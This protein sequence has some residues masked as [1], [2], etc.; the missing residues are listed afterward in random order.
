M[1]FIRVGLVSI[2]A[3]VLSGSCILAQTFQ[4]RI[5]GRVTDSSG[6]VIPN[7]TVT[8]ENTGTGL[9][10]VLQTNSSGDYFA[11]NLNPG[12]YS[13]N[14][15]APNFKTMRR[16]EIRLEVASDVRIDATLSPGAVSEV[17]QVTGEQPMVDI[18]T[19][20]LGGTMTNKAINELPLQ[21]RDFQ[22]LLELR[23]GV[24]RTP[25]GGFHTVTSNGNRL[26]DNNYTVDGT[27]DNDVYYGETVINDAGVAGTPASHL[28]LDAIQEFNT[29]ENQGAEYGW[30]PGAVVNIG[31]REWDGRRNDESAAPIAEED[32]N[33]QPGETGSDDGLL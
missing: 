16:S 19:D 31:D 23:P 2:L 21:G 25:G 11:P 22:N 8:I 32:Q 28:P 6:A 33:H 4:G 29:Q 1:K 20:T 17:M 10:R 12:I 24:Q 14:V 27:D 3:M 30:K 5:L 15:E 18:V 7:A 9:K 26:E 13:V